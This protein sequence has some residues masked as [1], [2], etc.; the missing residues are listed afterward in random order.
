ME[1]RPEPEA[2]QQVE[3]QLSTDFMRAQHFI[4]PHMRTTLID[5]MVCVQVRFQLL[6]DTLLLSIALLDRF[7]SVREGCKCINANKVR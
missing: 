3:Y 4:H 7:L 5:W 2:I 1:H 6:Q